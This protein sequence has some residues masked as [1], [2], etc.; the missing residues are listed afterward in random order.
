M[1]EQK[2][3]WRA[4][5]EATFGTD[6]MIW[7]DGLYTGG[8]ARQQGKARAETL[9]MLLLGLQLG[10]PVAA[11]ALG[12]M[13]AREALEGLRALLPNTRGQ[14]T[15]TVAL[16]IHDL[17]PDPALADEIIEVLRAH[18]LWGD[19]IKAAIALRRFPAEKVGDVLLHS[20][21]HD[22]D[23][24]VRYH[25]SDSYLR[26]HDVDPPEISEHPDIFGDIVTG[27]E[28]KPAPA[29]FQRFARAAE[30][31]RRLGTPGD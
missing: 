8:I 30:A 25:A 9:Q 7:H 29:D 12:A 28:R 3:A 22:P 21:A 13:G 6:Y 5:K 26:V 16:A 17:E 27:D 19:R 18:P 1:D 20:V 31:L 24:L 14:A 2:A 11:E 15:V 23:Y 10:D 4:W